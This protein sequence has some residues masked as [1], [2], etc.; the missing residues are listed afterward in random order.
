M[1]SSR[2]IGIIINRSF[3]IGNWMASQVVFTTGKFRN[4]FG[5]WVSELGGSLTLNM[6]EGTTIDAV[7]LCSHNNY[8]PLSIAKVVYL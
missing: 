5:T 1:L 3:L 7:K 4:N 6:V 2:A 8:I